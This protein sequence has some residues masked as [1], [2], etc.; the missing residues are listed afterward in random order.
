M[1]NQKPFIH[2]KDTAYHKER[3]EFAHKLYEDPHLL[4]HRYVFVLTNRCNLRC[5]FCFQEKSFIPGSMSTD[6]WL[7]LIDQLPEYA[8]VTLT[9][10]EPFIFKGFETVFRKVAE[11]FRCNIITNGLLL[12]E[13]LIELLLDYPNF[14]TLS[15]SVDDIGNIVRDVNPKKWAAAENMMRQFVKRRNER[16]SKT[17]LDSKTVVL[18]QNMADLLNIHKYCV[19]TLQCDT[20]SFQLLKGSPIQH[21]DIMFKYEEI[22]KTSEAPT[23]EK[24]DVLCDQLEK[25]RQ[26]NQD[27]DKSCYIHPKIADLNSTSPIDTKKISYINLKEFVP[28][29]YHPCKAM[30]ESVHINV[31]GH[32]FP[33]MAVSMGNVKEKPLAD[34]IHGELFTK[35]KTKI[36]QDGLVE[37]CNRCGY[38]RPQDR[39]L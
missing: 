34:I 14:K 8:W 37:A 6:D 5:S 3:Q 7:K 11:K 10:G 16:G 15:V 21:S 36:K 4:P 19:E 31:D 1:N 20:H 25:V 30:W 38:L 32:L 13:P 24:W 22:V 2:T 29:N 28:E 39:F 26:Y 33:C 23:Y 27:F 17:I 18:D 35:L 9:G 12:T